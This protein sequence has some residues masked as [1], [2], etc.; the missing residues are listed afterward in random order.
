MTDGLIEAKLPFYF[1]SGVDL[2]RIFQAT[3]REAHI[4]YV[5]TQTAVFCRLFHSVNLENSVNS[6]KIQW[7]SI[8]TKR[9]GSP[10]GR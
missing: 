5:L 7:P 8:H 3:H 4:L 6:V 2:C 1:L 9:K 10:A